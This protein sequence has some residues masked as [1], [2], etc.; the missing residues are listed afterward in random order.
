MRHGRGIAFE[1]RVCRCAWAR[2]RQR[3]VCDGLHWPAIRRWGISAWFRTA[4]CILVARA[5]TAEL[6]APLERSQPDRHRVDYD[7]IFE[8][9]PTNNAIASS[10][11]LMMDNPDVDVIVAGQMKREGGRSWRQQGRK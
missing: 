10:I 4:S 6:R 11:C 9:D 8:H 2:R 3:T 1:P 7:S 5:D